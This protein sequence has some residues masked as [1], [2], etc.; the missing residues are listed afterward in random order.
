[1]ETYFKNMINT[2]NLGLNPMSSEGTGLYLDTRSKFYKA[3]LR[4]LGIDAT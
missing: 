2:G 4:R 1:M 3:I